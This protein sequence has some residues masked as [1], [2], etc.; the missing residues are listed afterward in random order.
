MT[1]SVLAAGIC[2]HFTSY[3]CK[4]GSKCKFLHVTPEELAAQGHS[5]RG[6]QNH[7]GRGRG[8]RFDGPPGN[9][10]ETNNGG[11]MFSPLNRPTLP[12]LPLPPAPPTNI[13][14][15][16]GCQNILPSPPAMLAGHQN[17]RSSPPNTA[18]MDQTL[19]LSPPMIG[20]ELSQQKQ[21]NLQ[22]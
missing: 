6:R 15:P 8:E 18:G 1:A 17:I 3:G 9:H 11:D 14:S 21:I 22:C 5:P 4:L 2:K 10:F 19:R 16:P 20:R 12:L 7:R 13:T